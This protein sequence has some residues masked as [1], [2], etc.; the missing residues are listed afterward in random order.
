MY[1]MCPNHC[2]QYCANFLVW[3]TYSAIC[4]HP[5]PCSV[6]LIPDLPPI[7][8]IC[9]FTPLIMSEHQVNAWEAY[10]TNITF[11]LQKCQND[12]SVNLRQ[13][14]SLCLLRID[15]RSVWLVQ[16]IMHCTN[17][18]DG[19]INAGATPAESICREFGTRKSI[20]NTLK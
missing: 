18:W 11:I 7:Y 8:P 20:I 12:K 3:Q 4:L 2:N 5:L 14:A 1:K 19:L 10:D 9:A 16:G 17:R 6:I 13:I 15:Y